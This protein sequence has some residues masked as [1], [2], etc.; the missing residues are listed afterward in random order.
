M[1]DVTVHESC[2]VLWKLLREVPSRMCCWTRACRSGRFS[3]LVLRISPVWK[4]IEEQV[5]NNMSTSF[6]SV[7]EK[8][9]W[10]EECT[11]SRHYCK[12]QCDA[13]TFITLHAPAVFYSTSIRNTVHSVIRIALHRQS[14]PRSRKYHH[15]TFIVPKHTRARSR[16]R[17][18]SKCACGVFGAATR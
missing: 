16:C 10:T 13:Q 14:S 4:G 7:Q 5:C 18:C 11:L 1:S 8:H 3:I 9:N 2:V 12:M 6:S 15:L 17:R